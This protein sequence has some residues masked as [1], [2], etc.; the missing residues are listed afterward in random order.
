MSLQA[1]AAFSK[2]LKFPPQQVI[3][4]LLLTSFGVNMTHLSLLPVSRMG[5]KLNL[6]IVFLH[7][8]TL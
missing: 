4:S 8:V 1:R 5:L 6:S 3:V 7:L 2:N